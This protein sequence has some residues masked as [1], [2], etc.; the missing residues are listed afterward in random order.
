[1]REKETASQMRKLVKE[2]KSSGQ[3]QKEFS[4]AHGIKE[5]KLHYWIS[6]LEKSEQRVAPVITE[7]KD[8]IAIEVAPDHEGLSIMIRMKSGVEIE[9]PV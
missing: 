3:S 5:G 6:K 2:F 1:M 4:L 9:I 7:K 8:F